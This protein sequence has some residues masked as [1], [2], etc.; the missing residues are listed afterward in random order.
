METL[1]TPRAPGKPPRLRTFTRLPEGPRAYSV[2]VT[3]ITA[4]W[5]PPP[6]FRTPTTSGTEWMVYKS[7]SEIFGLPL[8][9]ERPPYFGAYPFWAYQQGTGGDGTRSK[10]DFVVYA[11]RKRPTVLRI[12]TEYRHVF[13]DNARQTYDRIQ[14][15]VLSGR[16]DV[17]DLYDSTFVNDKSGRACVVQVKAALGLLE[18]MDPIVAGTALRGSRQDTQA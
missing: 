10:P 4:F 12:Q 14:R 3:H 1:A 13:T 2:P 18:Q 16:Y 17:I 7:L 6:E 8:R 11:G 15:I 9:P 5:P